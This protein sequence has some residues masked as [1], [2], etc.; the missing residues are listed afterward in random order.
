MLFFLKS[1]IHQK[2]T[3][4]VVFD[5]KVSF[6]EI[7]RSLLKKKQQWADPGKNRG[8]AKFSDFSNF[9]VS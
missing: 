3:V 8:F 9:K 1:C 2:L 7:K 5:A 6:R 4:I